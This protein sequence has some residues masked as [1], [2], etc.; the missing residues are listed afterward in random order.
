MNEMETMILG[1][2]FFFFEIWLILQNKDG[3]LVLGAIASLVDELGAA[4]IHVEGRPMD[5]NRHVNKLPF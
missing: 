2:F 3:N 5:F 4:V 1:F